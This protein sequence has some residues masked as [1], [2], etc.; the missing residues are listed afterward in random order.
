MLF[1]GNLQG[2]MPFE[3]YVLV[4]YFITPERVTDGL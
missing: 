2:L 1:L 4:G 3:P